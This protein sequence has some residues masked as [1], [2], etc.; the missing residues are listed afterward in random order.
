MNLFEPYFSI[1]TSFKFKRNGA[2]EKRY[3]FVF[4]LLLFSFD[5]YG[6]N[7]VNID[8]LEQVYKDK[9]VPNSELLEVLRMIS[10]S[11]PDPDKALFYSQ[12]L[13]QN[14]EKSEATYYKYLGYLLKGN[15]LNEKGDLS[16]ALKSYYESA[17]ITEKIRPYNDYYMGDVSIAIAGVYSS[18]GDHSNSVQFYKKAIS[19]HKKKDSL[20]SLAKALENLGDEYLNVSKPDS[21]LIMF[22]QSGPV[23]KKLGYLPGI[24]MN[25]GNK[26]VA[27][28]YLGENE[29]AEVEI[30]HAM[31]MFEKMENYYAI[32]NF[33]NYLSDLYS[34]QG[35][36]DLALKYSKRSLEISEKYGLKGEISKAN[37]QLSNLYEKSGDPETSLYYYK[38][39]IA[40]KDSVNNIA[41]VQQMAD[42]RTD[43]EVSQ[44][45]LEVDLLQQKQRIQRIVLYSILGAFI[46]IV[47][48]AFGLFRRNKFIEKTKSLIEIERNRSDKL[49]LNILPE[50]TAQE[51]KEHG[52]VK[53]KKF[54]SVTV[55]FTDFK[56]F[57]ELSEDL[58][59]EDLVKS[60]DYYYQ[61]FD[62]IIKENSLEKIKT[63]GD[64]YMAAAGLPF[65]QKDHAKKLLSAAFEIDAFVKETK[66]NGPEGI[67]KFDIRIGLNSGPVVAGVVG[68]DKFAYDIWGDTVNIA[69][70]M[71]SSSIP[72]KINISEST[73]RLV[74]DDFD[75]EYRGEIQVKNKG[76]LKMYFV[77]GPKNNIQ[78]F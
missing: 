21:A 4:I 72:G 49:L 75:C 54:E 22:E 27:Y 58:S 64:S 68:S 71:E 47:A 13:I 45:Q 69:S 52:K 24:A 40:Y 26:G 12:E 61:K 1:L 44:K 33:L 46:L 25:I 35:E 36:L 30:N 16:Q 57:T 59:P 51:L 7:R 8:S 15:A 10:F 60:V 66:L 34:S 41:A 3:L 62:E 73:Y 11:H 65:P 32:S 5:S 50:Q 19:I 28:I 2:R 53:A 74:K 6:Q 70:R 48:L 42:I 9:Q 20:K 55:L 67:K 76:K 39:H 18:M 63:I 56:G 31:N 43:Y 29:L 17:K 78:S 14:A 37:L 23:F 38:N 77:I